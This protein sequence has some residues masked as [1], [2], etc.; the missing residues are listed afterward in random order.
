MAVG[1]PTVSGMRSERSLASLLLVQRL[2]ESCANPL[3]A[4]Q[5]WPLVEQT[6]GLERLLG[7]SA[8]VL[9][10][11]FGLEPGLAEQVAGRLDGAPGLTDQLQQLD[12]AGVRAITFVDEGY[13]HVLAERLKT[14]P[15]ILYVAGDPALLTTPM[16]GI[17]GSRNVDPDGAEVARA[18][19]R[20]AVRHG[21]GVASGG[22]KGVDQL[23]MRAALEAEGTVIGVLA[24]SLLRALRESE[25]RRAIANGQVCFCTPFNPS[26]GFSVANAMGRNKI[27]YALSGATLVVASEEDSGGTWA[28]AKEALTGGIAP[29]L[30]WVGPGSGPGNAALVRRGA[31]ELSDLEHLFP[32]PTAASGRDVDPVKE[33]L[34][35]GL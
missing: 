9:V 35:L 26:A 11:E 24:D 13:P 2:A 3:T 27:V 23:S 30:S 5:Y 6:G 18:A 20:A 31:I 7:K 28:G 12:Q 8:D 15:P 29:V 32:L 10:T 14:A 19:A 17:V 33:Q 1:E 34:R 25:T 21:H 22:A 16:L 4:S